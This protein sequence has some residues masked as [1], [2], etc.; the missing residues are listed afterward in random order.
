MTKISF[1]VD[2]SKDS[3]TLLKEIQDRAKTEVEKRENKERAKAYLSNLHETVNQK[4][5]TSYKNPTDLIR[6]LAEHASPGMRERISGSTSIGRRKTVSMTKD[7]FAKIKEG[8]AQSAPNKAAI[9]RETGVSVVQVRK[10]ATGG[11]DER[12]DDESKGT[13]SPTPLI[14][15]PVGTTDEPEEEIPA[16]EPESI[17]EESTP[18]ESLSEPEPSSDGLPFPETP[19]ESGASETTDEP[20]ALPPPPD[21]ISDK[22]SE[23]AGEIVPPPLPEPI[24]TEEP[25]AS[26]IPSP[27]E[28]LM[29]E[30]TIEE[31][32]AGLPEPP[33]PSPPE[34][35]PPGEGESLEPSLPVDPGK[36]SLKLGGGK[37]KPSIKLGDK[38][39]SGGLPKGKFSAKITRPPLPPGIAPPDS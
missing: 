13:P 18:S 10:V 4:I 38:S 27:P 22:E 23:P 8:L 35:P 34:P 28:S 14:E 17:E 15:E 9:A 29:P 30:P 1:D 36:P 5:G 37:K 2:F 19:E 39:G 3:E 20:S 12:F 25:V 7:I 33:P 24:P 6:A 21:F 26:D 32:P 16:V 11:F 31:T